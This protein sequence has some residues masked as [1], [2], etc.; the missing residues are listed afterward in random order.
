MVRLPL[1]WVG[2]SVR[3]V[4]LE[5]GALEHSPSWLFCWPETSATRLSVNIFLKALT[6]V[7]YLN[8]DHGWFGFFLVLK[9]CVSFYGQ[10]CIIKPL[11]VACIH[12]S[13]YR[14][15]LSVSMY[16]REIRIFHDSHLLTHCLSGY[17][18]IVLEVCLVWPRSR[19]CLHCS[20]TSVHEGRKTK[21]PGVD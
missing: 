17:R 21:T 11:Q 19:F 20:T 14:A 6:G 9:K 10:F 3:S 2:L 16:H 4:T 12:P 8:V 13:V 15:V 5:D 7:P 18:V 1:V